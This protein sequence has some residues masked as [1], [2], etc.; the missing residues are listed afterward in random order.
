MMGKI[1][2]VAI[3]AIALVL[4]IGF[5]V[6]AFFKLI[7]P[8]QAQLT[9]LQAKLEEEQAKADE[10]EDTQDE[11]IKVTGRW[12]GADTKL[13]KLMDRRSIKL[14]F[15]HP[16]P[17]LFASL[18]P[19]MRRNLANTIEEW[20]E[21]Q[22]V[23]IT[24]GAGIPAPP[25]LP[26][27]PPPNGF[28]EVAQ[29]N[30][31]IQGTLS[32]IEKLYRALPE[33]PRIGIIDSLSLSG[34]G[35]IISAALPM[36]IYLLVEVPPELAAPVA[37]VPGMMGPGMMGPGMMGPGM[38]GPD[39]MRPDMMGGPGMMGPDMM[40]PDMMGP[41]GMPMGQGMDQRRARLGGAGPGA[42]PR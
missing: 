5:A 21:S 24:S 14:S 38:M 7:K 25:Q 41:G 30:L 29:I 23:T 13:Q 42:R 19:E 32:Q 20:V 28:Y 8:A 40:R 18:W 4:I 2:P 16:M 35:D 22:G 33:F 3:I 17:A 15:G 10:L 26:P 37:A 36:T 9:D 12:L 6:G 31:G 27:A 1:P 34:E 11:L 39:M